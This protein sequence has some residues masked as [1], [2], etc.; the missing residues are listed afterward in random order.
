[1]FLGKLTE[2]GWKLDASGECCAQCPKHAEE[3]MEGP[4]AESLTTTG[5]TAVWGEA[6]CKLFLE[7]S[8]ASLLERIYRKK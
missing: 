5:R 8:P 2:E 7:P 4:V 6:V 3:E 1:M